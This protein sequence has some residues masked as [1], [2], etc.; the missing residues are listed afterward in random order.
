MNSPGGRLV[1]LLHA[2]TQSPE[3]LG[4]VRGAIEEAWPDAEIFAPSL[5]LARFSFANAAAVARSIFE[6]IDRMVSRKAGQGEAYRDIVLVGHSIGGL[7]ARRIYLLACGETEKAPFEDSPQDSLEPHK[8]W[9]RNVTRIVLLAGMNRGWSISHHMGLLK[10][11]GMTVVSFLA[12]IWM[13][14]T[15]TRLLIFQ[16]RRGA[17]FLTQ[18]R[19][20]WIAMEQQA[21]RENRKTATVVQLLG[22][23]DDVVSPEDNVDLVA[24][25]SFFYLDV[26]WSGHASVI[27]MDETPEGRDRKAVF[28]R[29]LTDSEGSLRA[30]AAMPVDEKPREADDKV[31]HVIFVIHGIRDAGYWTQKIARCVQRTGNQVPVVYAMETSTYGYFAMFPFL[32]P[33]RRREKVEWL[34]DQFAEAQAL[35]PNA[36]FSFVG[37]SNGTYLL[38]KALKEYRACRFE[39][40]VFAGSVVPR[41]YDW[42][43]AQKRGQITAVLNYVATRD[44][45]V[46]WFP[47][48]IEKL[49]L[50]DLGSAGHNGFDQ[51]EPD[52]K[53]GRYQCKYVP[54]GHAAALREEN[55]QAIAHFIVHGKPMDP[56]A[57]RIAERRRW[58]VV[59][60]GW[61]APLIWVAIIWGLYLIVVWIWGRPI[62]EWQR[63]LAEVAFFWLVWKILTRV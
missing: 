40:V 13:T 5:P 15:R 6:E 48:A 8:E 63:T 39:N 43:A 60:P 52:S 11:A 3:G 19:L 56:P 42:V 47:G 46:A 4:H 22:S 24:G 51:L 32:L 31:T 58:W 44:L 55:W 25:Q 20:Q 35:Y 10:A 21:R 18:L 36:K 26:P 12:N 50:Q 23:V 33:S 45:I 29:A 17:P 16:I 53:T 61:V 27:L 54:G 57:A 28:L 9:S 7:L 59:V 49:R 30:A 34:M 14:V 2:Y 41:W 1:V 62:A 38:A 37:H